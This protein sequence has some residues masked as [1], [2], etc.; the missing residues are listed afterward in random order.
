[1]GRGLHA[2]ST[3]F[4]LS[5]SRL[6]SMT[7]H[8]L[9]TQAFKLCGVPG[10]RRGA[11]HSSCTWE[12]EQSC[13]V[14]RS[15]INPVATIQITLTY[16]AGLWYSERVCGDISTPMLPYTV[17]M[18]NDRFVCTC[19]GIIFQTQSIDERRR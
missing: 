19:C 5:G 4:Y 2:V 14:T 15:G 17:S 6:T 12:A 10:F 11:G 1:M 13:A 18:E 16:R 3:T 9:S 7:Y 8:T